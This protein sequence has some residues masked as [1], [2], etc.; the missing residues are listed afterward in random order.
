M[1]VCVCVCDVYGR[2]N[3]RSRSAAVVVVAAATEG[4]WWFGRSA[5]GQTGG[6]AAG[7]Q[8]AIYLPLPHHSS[9]TAHDFNAN[10][11][12]FSVTATASTDQYWRVQSTT[13]LLYDY[14][15]TVYII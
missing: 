2:C 4:V 13:P 6:V 8:W 15:I 5:I 3:A 10:P 14:N 12:E 7:Q 9:S 11:R 1:C